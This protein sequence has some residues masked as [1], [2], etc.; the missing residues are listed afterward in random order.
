MILL[1]LTQ[2]VADT[3]FFYILKLIKIKSWIFL[4]IIFHRKLPTLSHSDLLFFFST[5]NVHFCLKWI[6]YTDF[7]I[8]FNISLFN[9]LYISKWCTL[10]YWDKFIVIR[11]DIW[12][13]FGSITIRI[14]IILVTERIINFLS[15]ITCLI[16]IMNRRFKWIWFLTFNKTL[17]H[18]KGFNNRSILY[19]IIWHMTFIIILEWVFY[20]D[21][22]PF[23]R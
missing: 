21:A 11:C 23:F 8:N 3:V 16:R 1:F 6:I 17:I 18:F 22:H 20:L 19:F 9:F 5:S 7:T 2:I 4:F 13:E 15:I 14:V 12:S 10:T